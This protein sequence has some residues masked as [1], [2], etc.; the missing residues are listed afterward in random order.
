MKAIYCLVLIISLNSIC[1]SQT[2]VNKENNKYYSEKIKLNTKATEYIDTI[3]TFRNY[4]KNNDEKRI[5]RN[6][7][8]IDKDIDTLIWECK[9]IARIL[10][11]AN[12]MNKFS[13]I[14]Y[15]IDNQKNIIVSFFLCERES[16]KTVE[17]MKLKIKN[18]E[19]IGI[20]IL[21]CCYDGFVSIYEFDNSIF[22][23]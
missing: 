12:R 6:D 2:F 10:P 18:K 11:Y 19:I 1:F 22:E 4:I 16:R 20:N 7:L 9:Y 13:I 14:S 17:M 5:V 21:P 15:K 3:F 8:I 23:Y